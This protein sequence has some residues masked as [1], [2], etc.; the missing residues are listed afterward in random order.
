MII[1]LL[2]IYAKTDQEDVSL[3][4]LEEMIEDIPPD[5]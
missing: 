1:Y 5:N 3:T 2:F 4:Q